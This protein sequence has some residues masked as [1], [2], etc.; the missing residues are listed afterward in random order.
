M[1]KLFIIGFFILMFGGAGL[2][3]AN[4]LIP[5]CICLVG[6][7]IMVLSAVIEYLKN[8]KNSRGY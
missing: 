2:D 5:V 1:E 4:M 6:L 8:K 3:S 7:L